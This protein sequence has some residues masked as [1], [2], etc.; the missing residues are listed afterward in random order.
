[1]HAGQNASHDA[2]GQEHG[3]QGLCDERGGAPVC[4]NYTDDVPVDLTSAYSRSHIVFLQRAQT[5]AQHAQRKV[6]VL[7]NN[8]ADLT[9]QDDARPEGF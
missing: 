2:P 9:V 4:V 3:L 7:S 8:P 5:A 1:M 6:S